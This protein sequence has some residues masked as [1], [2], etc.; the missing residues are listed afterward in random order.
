MRR[1]LPVRVDDDLDGA[2][3]DDVEIVGGVALPI[4]VFTGRHRSA[5]TELPQRRHFGVVQLPE[6]IVG[7]SHRKNPYLSPFAF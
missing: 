4:Q 6:G 5:N 2:G 1:S 7:V 3:K